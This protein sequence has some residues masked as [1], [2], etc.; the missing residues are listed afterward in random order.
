MPTAPLLL[1]AARDAAGNAEAALKVAALVEAPGTMTAAIELLRE[2]AEI[3]LTVARVV[4]PHL[5][6]LYILREADLDVPDGIFGVFAAEAPGV[7][8]EAAS[9]NDGWRL[10]GVK[11]WCSLAGLLDQALVTAT[12]GGGRRLFMVD[13]HHPGVHA[14][15]AAWVARG[16]TSVVTSDL[17]FND[18]PA[19]AVGD[20]DWYLTRPGFAWGGIRVAACWAGATQALVIYLSAS[21]AARSQPDPIRNANLGRADVA[22]WSARLALDHA[23]RVIDAGDDAADCG[24]AE[25]TLLA[26]RTRAVVADAVE[27]VLREVGHALGPAPLAFADEHARRVADLTLYVRQHHAERDLAVLGTLVT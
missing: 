3:D 21:L 12:T 4:E 6:A 20:E 11:P 18:V 24:P 10:S 25:A 14:S 13:L 7:K 17:E 26:A 5:D 15:G 22:S 16:L 27:L 23:G 8:L 2:L 19:E 9:T 1:A